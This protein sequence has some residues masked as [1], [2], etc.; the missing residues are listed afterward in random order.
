LIV[1]FTQLD[2]L[3]S[4]IAELEDTIEQQKHQLQVSKGKVSEISLQILFIG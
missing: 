1:A 2:V 3:S 4:G